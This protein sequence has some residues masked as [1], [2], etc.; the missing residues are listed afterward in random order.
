MASESDNTLVR[1]INS[2][3]EEAVR[4]NA[5]D[6]HIETADEPRQ[7][8]VRMRVDGE[9]VP[10]LEVPARLRFAIVARI[11]I[12]AELDISEHRKPQDGKIDFA[13]ASAGRRWSCAWSPCRPR[14]G[15]KTWCC[16]CSAAA[17]PMALEQIGLADETWPRCA[18]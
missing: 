2:L 9:L 12:M 18:R 1:L 7:V 6:I 11:K 3:I 5:S 17:K 16:A 13:R 14:A 15:S 4:R 8:Q 10:V